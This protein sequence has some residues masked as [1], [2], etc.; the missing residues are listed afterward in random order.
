MMGD[1]SIIKCKFGMDMFLHSL[2]A[3]ML[4]DNIKLQTKIG[5]TNSF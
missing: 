5:F 3:F 2:R 4:C 1:E